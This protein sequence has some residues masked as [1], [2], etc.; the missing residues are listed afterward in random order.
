MTLPDGALFCMPDKIPAEHAD[1]SR[2]RMRQLSVLSGID[3]KTAGHGAGV[4]PEHSPGIPDEIL[5]KEGG[6][7]VGAEHQGGDVRRDVIP[8][9]ECVK[10]VPAVFF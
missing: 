1:L 4:S 7:Q 2:I 8:D 5:K 10:T 6:C 3:G 9:R